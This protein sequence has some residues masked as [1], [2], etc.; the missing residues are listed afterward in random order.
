MVVVRFQVVL[1]LFVE[2]ANQ[3]S[4]LLLSLLHSRQDILV[5]LEHEGR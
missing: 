4:E 2:V 5:V 3:L 1:H